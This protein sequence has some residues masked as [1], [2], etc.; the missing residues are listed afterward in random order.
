M[1][2]K[3][4]GLPSPGVVG[5]PNWYKGQ[6]SANPNGRPRSRID[7]KKVQ[8]VRTEAL[9]AVA[10][11]VAADPT[12]AGTP[13]EPRSAVQILRDFANDPNV[14]TS[15][16]ISAAAAAAPY[17]QPKL[18]AVPDPVFLDTQ[19]VLPRPEPST[20]DQMNANIWHIHQ[21]K[22][23]GQIDRE[24]GDNLINDQRA[25]GNNII[26]Q[27]KLAASTGDTTGEQIIRIQGGLPTLPGCEA[28]LMPQLNGNG[29]DP[30]GMLPPQPVIPS[31]PQT[32]SSPV[33]Q[34]M[35]TKADG[36]IFT[37]VQNNKGQW[38]LQDKTLDPV[39][40][41]SGDMTGTAALHCHPTLA[42]EAKN[43]APAAKSYALET[44]NHPHL[45][46]PHSRP[47]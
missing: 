19:I 11:F 28:L 7:S 5:N 17:E 40:A 25:L 26:D 45:P 6:P 4:E 9:T 35:T 2:W 8:K 21:L 15:L 41:T 22:L 3:E 10:E 1:G 44:Q 12:V 27:N 23:S 34:T 32:N 20:I 16:R 36:F 37:W 47:L 46:A 31:G 43:T 18:L 13:T 39:F 33:I 29:H 38:E 24:W 30:N 42:P 14:Q